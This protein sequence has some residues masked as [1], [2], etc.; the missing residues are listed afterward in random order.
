MARITPLPVVCFGCL[1]GFVALAGNPALVQAD[2]LWPTRRYGALLPGDDTYDQFEAERQAG[3]A[4]QQGLVDD[5]AW[6]FGPE[7]APWQ[8][9]GAQWLEPFY[10]E[11]PAKDG[12]A[13]GEIPAE[14]LWGNAAPAPR[15]IAAPRNEQPARRHIEELPRP[16][17]LPMPRELA[18]PRAKPQAA[19]AAKAQAKPHAEPRDNGSREF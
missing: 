17:E 8:E 9:N 4:A 2:E 12:D 13:W 1:V 18:E 10:T 6:E 16:R 14:D 15:V 7:L 19:P 5:L 3:V 11:P